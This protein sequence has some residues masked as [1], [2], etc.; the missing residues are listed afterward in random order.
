MKTRISWTM[1]VLALV[2]KASLL[3]LLMV[4]LS[5]WIPWVLSKK[6]LTRIFCWIFHPMD[7]TPKQSFFTQPWVLAPNKQALV[8]AQYTHIY[9]IP[10]KFRMLWW[11]IGLYSSMPSTKSHD[12]GSCILHGKTRMWMSVWWL[13][14]FSLWL[15]EPGIPK[16]WIWG[17]LFV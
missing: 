2:Q 14:F 7:P 11:S 5:C 3:C 4:A 13:Q 6:V 1:M 8:V 17:G 10:D 9:S 15:F 12:K 16:G